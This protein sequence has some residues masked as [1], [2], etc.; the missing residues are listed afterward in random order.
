MS[1]E[2]LEEARVKRVTKFQVQVIVACSN[3]DSAGRCIVD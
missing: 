2:D 1:F 3:V